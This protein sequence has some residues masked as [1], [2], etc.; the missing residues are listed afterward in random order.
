MNLLGTLTDTFVTQ[1]VTGLGHYDCAGLYGPVCGNPDPHWKHKLRLT[2][3][4]P[5]HFDI[6]G[7]WRY[8]GGVKLDFDESNPLLKNGYYDAVDEHMAGVSYFDLS[9]N[10]RV[11]DGLTVRAGVTN[12]FDKDPPISSL[13]AEEVGV[14]NGNTF[15]GVY[16]ALGRQFFI[17]LTAKF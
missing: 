10:W 8:I 3:S 4:T 7:D 5:W 11:K 16:D 12:I 17:G 13:G 14:G 2:W 1:P 6:S 9:G 15:P